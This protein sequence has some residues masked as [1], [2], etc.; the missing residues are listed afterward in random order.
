[1][2]QHTIGYTAEN[3]ACSFLLKQGYR[4]Q[5]RNFHCKFGEI[6]LIMLNPQNE[7]VFI[8]VRYRKNRNFGVA[9]AS[10][11]RQK[12]QK[13]TK[14]AAYYLQKQHLYEQPCRFDVIAIVGSIKPTD[15]E[16]IKDA[17]QV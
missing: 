13:I 4:L 3:Y 1:M 9:L 6:D 12:Q 14:T 16:W 7:L 10:I 15:L 17:F 8:E 5:E 2:S 11:T